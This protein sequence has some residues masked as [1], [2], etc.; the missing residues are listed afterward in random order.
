MDRSQYISLRNTTL[1]MDVVRE[2]TINEYSL[3]TI[4]EVNKCEPSQHYLVNTKVIPEKQGTKWIEE[5][6]HL[7]NTC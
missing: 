2:A 6:A 7:I 4:C 3:L 5:T 1:E